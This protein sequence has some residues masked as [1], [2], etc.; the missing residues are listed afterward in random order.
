MA[1]TAY[2]I[3]MHWGCR[4]VREMWEEI[5][6]LDRDNAKEA[7]DDVET[8][9][10]KQIVRTGSCS[11]PAHLLGKQCALVYMNR[12]RELLE[13]VQK[14]VRGIRK[15]KR[16]IQTQENSDVAA[17]TKNEVVLFSGFR[18]DSR[19]AGVE[20]TM[21]AQKIMERARLEAAAVD[22]GMG[23]AE[24]A[25]TVHLHYPSKLGRSGS[26]LNPDFEGPR[27]P[28]DCVPAYLPMIQQ[29]LAGS[30]PP[31]KHSKHYRSLGRDEKIRP[32]HPGWEE[33]KLPQN[34]PKRG[35]L[36]REAEAKRARRGEVASEEMAEKLN[37]ILAANGPAVNFLRPR[38]GKSAAARTG[39]SG[40]KRV[41]RSYRHATGPA[42]GG[43]G[44]AVVPVDSTQRATTPATAASATTGGGGG[45]GCNQ[46]DDCGCKGVNHVP[47][48]EKAIA[49]LSLEKKKKKKKKKTKIAKDTA[50]GILKKNTAAHGTVNGTVKEK[51]VQFSDDT[52]PAPEEDAYPGKP[53]YK[54]AGSRHFKT[55]GHGEGIILKS[56]RKRC[57][58]EDHGGAQRRN[59]RLR[60]LGCLS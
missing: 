12:R 1:D 44:A 59:D 23:E 36:R 56:L 21:R 17:K 9:V 27:I 40:R 20:R 2:M 58:A 60:G 47:E 10:V 5:K 42:Y 34:Q 31:L 15:A 6:Y 37:E 46:A 41:A 8:L 14:A 30:A 39:W 28:G 54:P 18:A 19:E 33:R 53:I 7:M 43:K 4:V 38:T 16:N 57:H 11:M 3:E 35:T 51:T 24:A 50:R 55:E 32:F 29:R 13:P 48:V 49:A 45:G 52:K 26:R 22:R 25:R